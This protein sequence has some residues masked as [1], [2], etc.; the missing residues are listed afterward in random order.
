M[1]SIVGCIVQRHINM[2]L[3][4]DVFGWNKVFFGLCFLFG[5]G[6]AIFALIFLA[7]CFGMLNGQK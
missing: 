3:P 1:F 4:I 6:G 2:E 5:F 7:G